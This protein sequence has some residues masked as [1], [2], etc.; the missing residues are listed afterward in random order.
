MYAML[1]ARFKMFPEVKEK[2]MSS[3]P[4]LVA[5]T[6]EHVGTQFCCLIN[7]RLIDPISKHRIFFFLL[8]ELFTVSQMLRLPDL[9]LLWPDVRHRSHPCL[10]SCLSEPFFN[11]KRRGGSRHRHGERDLHQSRWKV[12]QFKLTYKLS[13]WAH[14][15]KFEVLHPF[16]TAPRSPYLVSLGSLYPLN[17]SHGAKQIQTLLAALTSVFPPA[18]LRSSVQFWQNN[19]L[20]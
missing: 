10:F 14:W 19:Y 12:K 3:V 20:V 15:P 8:A 2:G 18:G 7:I 16:S 4:R 13:S 6:S 17:S 9:S 1:L 11:Q 5:F